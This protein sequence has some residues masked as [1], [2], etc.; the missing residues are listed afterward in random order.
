MEGGVIDRVL[1]CDSGNN[2]RKDN[3][4]LLS[5]S[6]HLESPLGDLET[7]TET[8]FPR[9][10]VMMLQMLGGQRD[11]SSSSRRGFHEN[12]ILLEE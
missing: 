10:W 4:L 12:P 7:R 9:R 11:A 1:G 2:E 5:H 8:S 6:H 3:C